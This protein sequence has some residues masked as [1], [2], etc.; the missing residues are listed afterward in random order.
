MSAARASP[1]LPEAMD[2]DPRDREPVEPHGEDHREDEPEPEARDRVDE[3]RPGG[4]QPVGGRPRPP[5]GDDAEER[6]EQEGERRR[7]A[8]QPERVRQP[9]GDHLRDRAIERDRIAEIAPGELAEGEGEARE[10]RAVE[11]VFGAKRL[12]HRRVAATDRD[13][14][15]IDRVAAGAV[16]QQEDADDDD[17]QHRDAAEKP[18]DDEAEEARHLSAPAARSGHSARAVSAQFDTAQRGLSATF[19]RRVEA[20]EVKVQSATLIS[21]RSAV[22]SRW[23]S[24]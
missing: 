3:K 23:N 1:V 18:G 7:G 14:I 12:G 10:H 13:E 8:H 16:E 11:P 2:L 19:S 6:A 20:T 17:Q 24:R 5:A 4:E 21:G 9:L 15:G 22:T